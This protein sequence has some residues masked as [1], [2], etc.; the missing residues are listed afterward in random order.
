MNPFQGKQGVRIDLDNISFAYGNGPDVLKGIELSIAAGEKV[1]VVGASGG[2]KSTLVQVLLGLYPPKVG[3]IKYDG[4]SVSQIGFNRVREHVACV[5]QQPAL[6]NDSLRMNLTLGRDVAE[7]QLWQVLEVAKIRDLVDELPEGLDTL[8]GLNGVRLSGGQKQRVAIARMA[9]SNPN[10]VILDEASSALDVDTESR[11]H[12]CL[13]EFLRDRTTIIIA[14]RLSAVQQADR[15]FVFEDGTIR[16]Q[17]KHQELL[18]SGGLYAQLY[19]K[20][21]KQQ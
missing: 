4:I 5:L 15:V 2:G 21:D 14:H 10:V 3:D 12:Q 8:L 20:Q 1:A 9:L 19:G 17:G 7:E 6:F 13:Q 18:A 16:E 11:V